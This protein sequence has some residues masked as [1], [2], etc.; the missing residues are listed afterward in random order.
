[1]DPAT[2]SDVVKFEKRY[3]Y[4][5]MMPEDVAIWQRFIEQFPDAYDNVSYDV[6][7]GK[8]PDFVTGHEDPAMQA[9]ANLYQRKIDVVG[10]K[11]DQI[12]IIELKPRAST[13]ALG[14]VNGYRHLFM[15]DY[16]PP[17]TPKAVVITNELLPEM[18][19]LAHAAGVTIV[20]V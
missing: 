8:A 7:V 6:K 1:M 12:D 5:H 17:E 16:S 3:W 18:G 4:A 13:S 15:R 14:Q 20:V 2:I 10:Y 9:Q 11:D 19:E